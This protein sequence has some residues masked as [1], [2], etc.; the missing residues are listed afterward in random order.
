MFIYD[1]IER[2]R[3]KPHLW[4]H[5]EAR[6]RALAPAEPGANGCML[7]TRAR[8]G[9]G[10]GS[11]KILQGFCVGA[12]R[13]AYALHHGTSPGDKQVCHQCDTPLCVNP[14]HLFLGTNTENIA[15]RV[16]KG[17][18]NRAGALGEKN[19]AA[20]LTAEQV[21]AIRDL[22]ASGQTNVRIAARYDVSHSLISAIRRGKAWKVVGAAGIEPATSAV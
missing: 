6:F 3:A 20:R 2:C 17:R 4:E 8:F 22:I 11:F 1:P 16:A 9:N 13:M 7:W 21:S 10:Y 15:D 12:H 19:P 18:S 5:A 14:A